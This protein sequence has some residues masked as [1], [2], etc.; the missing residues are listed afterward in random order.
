M[1]CLIGKLFSGRKSGPMI[2]V[3]RD[4]CAT[5]EAN[6][7]TRR[8]QQLLLPQLAREQ[9]QSSRLVSCRFC[10][11]APCA[12]CT[13]HPAFVASDVRAAQELVP[14]CCVQPRA[15]CLAHLAALNCVLSRY[16]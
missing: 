4:Y 16:H 12:Y 11:F 5:R 9:L 8:L 10:T 15:P 7:A 2:I 1:T 3:P 14:H 6:V 13:L